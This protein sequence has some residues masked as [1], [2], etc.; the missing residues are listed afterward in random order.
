MSARSIRHEA[1]AWLD[2]QAELSPFADYASQMR[3]LAL[4]LRGVVDGVVE[5]VRLTSIDDDG[6]AILVKVDGKPAASLVLVKDAELTAPILE[7]LGGGM[8]CGRVA[9]IDALEAAANALAQAAVRLG[10]VEAAALSLDRITAEQ[11]RHW[12]REAFNAAAD[13]RVAA[14]HVRKEIPR[15]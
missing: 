2:E 1:A 13:A 7:R 5:L 11:A 6:R 10:G 9:A 14:V 15:P 12:A 4:R 3:A 8:V